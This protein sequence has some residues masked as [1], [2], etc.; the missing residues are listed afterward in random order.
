MIQVLTPLNRHLRTAL[1]APGSSSWLIDCIRR[2]LPAG[3]A[4]D[5]VSL[6][7]SL[8]GRLTDLRKSQGKRHAL[9]SLVSVAAA[10]VAAAC[11]GPLA[12]AQAAAGWDQE[13]LAAHGCWMSPRT[14][15]RSAPSASML[16]RL[17]KL[18]DPDEFEAAL[19]AAVAAA[20][21]DPA[22]PAAYAAHRAEQRREEERERRKKGK[23]PAAA[24]FR[25]E[26]EDDWFRPHPAHPWLDPAACGDPGH[27]PA[28]QGVAVDGKERKG[29][30][31]GGGKKAHMPA[32]VT[33]TPGIVIARDRVAKAGKANEISHFKP[34]LAPLPLADA[35]V[36]TD[37]M[38]A[39]RDNS[40]FLR[41][42][43]D[44]HW[45]WPILGNQP[46]LN[47]QLNALGWG[48]TPVAA[49]TSEVTRGRIETRTIRVLPAPDGTG[50]A[51]AQQ[52]L[53]I[54]RYV[55]Y[56]KKGHWRT[57]AESVLYLT[58]LSAD[59]TTPEDL[60]AHVRGHWRVEHAH[61][62]RD[63]IWKEDKSLI[64]TGNG[65]QIWSA[66][67]NLV[68]TLFRI[69]GVTRFTEETRRIAQ[70]PRRAL[71]ILDLTG[72]LPG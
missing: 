34:L 63:V 29:A 53:L 35:V 51:D 9:A 27:V 68:I 14:G 46:N 44:A 66:V 31:S 21:L 65:P 48:N 67:A 18:V 19:T 49:A 15:K 33:H 4:P 39:N 69:H 12:I 26:R 5:P 41:A 30:K 7:E 24:G 55:T 2:H 20:A 32:A 1:A 57:R 42:A 71:R 43:K 3:T 56:K 38:Q 59:E 54:E 10:G 17:P 25:E 36:T 60:L 45:L 23:P 64:R 58:S 61:W 52:A 40:L 70:D 8:E 62:L 50:F 28:R 22:V 6:R 13:V 11:A 37:A 47:A 72:L 16:D